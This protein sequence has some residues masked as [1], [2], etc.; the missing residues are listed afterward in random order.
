MVTAQHVLNC[1]DVD[2]RVFLWALLA[3]GA[4]GQKENQ[5]KETKTK[6]S[7]LSYSKFGHT[8]RS[9]AGGAWPAA[10][11]FIERTR[12]LRWQWNLTDRLGLLTVFS[13]EAELQGALA[14]QRRVHVYCNVRLRLLLQ[15]I[16]RPC[17]RIRE[18]DDFSFSCSNFQRDNSHSCWWCKAPS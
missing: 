8:G 13:D 10:E 16:H 1:G 14:L 12:Q 11:S 7:I 6:K 17:R 2:R 18:P 3:P 4:W 15:A 5:L 9:E